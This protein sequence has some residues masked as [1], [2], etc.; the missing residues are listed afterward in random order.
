MII[1]D[2]SGDSQVSV[3][4]L[5]SVLHATQTQ[6][7]ELCSGVPFLLT[8]EPLWSSLKTHS[9]A[10]HSENCFSTV[11]FA[12]P[13]PYFTQENARPHMTRVTMNCLAACQTLPWSSR[14]PDISQ[15]KHVW[16]MKGGRLQAG[17][18]TPY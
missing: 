4:I 10:V 7:Q 12:V 11:T 5:L 3:P 6:N 2:V 13:W 14:S 9:T 16:D 1:E 8:A 15:I 17:G 18:S